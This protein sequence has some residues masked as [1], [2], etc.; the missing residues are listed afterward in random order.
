MTKINFYTTNAED[1]IKTFCKI[2]EKCYYSN[3]RALVVVESEEDLYALDKS[4]WTYSKEHFIPHATMDDLYA[5]E[6]PIIITKEFKN[7]NNAKIVISVNPT[8]EI[9]L[10]NFNI[11]LKGFFSKIEKVIFI[12]DDDSTMST[13]KIIEILNT[14]QLTYS[15]IKCFVKKLKEGWIIS[16]INNLS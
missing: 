5:H 9:I 8:K 11:S 14:S 4:L 10:K 2:S 3:S 13:M 15:E 12:L 7:L 6:Q 1:T 16:E